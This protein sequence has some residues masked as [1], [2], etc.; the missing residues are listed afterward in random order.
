MDWYFFSPFQ[1]AGLC[2]MVQN[3]NQKHTSFYCASCALKQPCIVFRVRIVVKNNRDRNSYGENANNIE[4][5]TKQIFRNIFWHLAPT[6]FSNVGLIKFSDGLF[7]E[8]IKVY[9]DISLSLVAQNCVRHLWN[10][11]FSRR[12][13]CRF[14]Y[15]GMLLGHRT[16][17]RSQK[18][19]RFGSSSR[20]R[21]FK[22]F[23][24]HVL[25]YS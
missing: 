9:L 23:Y 10:Y 8:S 15:S 20:Y 24:W 3:K 17:L 11:A 16:V 5:T 7:G 18:T 21:V 12:C 22:V 1:T 14:K 25:P 4:V 6:I 19:W 13:W 2:E